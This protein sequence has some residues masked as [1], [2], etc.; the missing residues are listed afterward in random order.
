M[1][2]IKQA[3]EKARRAGTSG[4][5]TAVREAGAAP[6]PQRLAGPDGLVYTQSRVVELD[7]AHLERHRIVAQDKFHPLG[8]GFDLLRTQVLRRMDENDWR[9]LAIISP[10]PGSG[11]TVLSIN[12]AISIAQHT[13]RTALLVDFDLRRPRVAKYLG[14]PTERSLNDYLDDQASLPEIMVNPGIPRLVILPTDRPVLKSSEVLTSRKVGD[15]ISELRG[16]YDSRIVIFDLPPALNADDAIAI[17]PKLDCS[18]LIVANGSDNKAEIEECLR[19]VPKANF[20]GS[21][22][23]K[24][25]VG[26]S[27]YRYA[28]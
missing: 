10:S 21:V 8:V 22:L 25:D 20:L 9:T 18:L 7:A 11:K 14:I 12:L 26:T 28:Y 1:E 23:N 13:E 4:L 2:R 15:V 6:R 24:A 27:P 3:L 5:R 17:L 19:L 16:R